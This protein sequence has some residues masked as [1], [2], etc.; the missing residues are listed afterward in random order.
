MEAD[1]AGE[2]GTDRE[3]WMMD[4]TSGKAGGHRWLLGLISCATLLLASTA[5]PTCSTAQQ[6]VITAPVHN[7]H[8]SY[9]ERIGI[10]MDYSWRGPR[11]YMFFNTHGLF[12]APPPFGGWDGND[13][14]FGFGWNRGNA[15]FNFNMAFGQG[16][17]RTH[18]MVA[19]SITVPNGYG[20]SIFSG[21]LRPFVTGIVPV[22]G[23]GWSVQPVIPFRP[24]YDDLR[25][26]LRRINDLER[27]STQTNS[28]T[29]R[30]PQER[31]PDLVLGSSDNPP[32]A[33]RFSSSADRGDESLAAIRRQLENEDRKQLAKA[34]EL[35]IE[36]QQAELSG[37]K[38]VARIFYRQ[39]A[40]RCQG[41]LQKK[42]LLHCE[43]LKQ[44]T[45]EK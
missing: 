9:Y 38:G 13:G 1:V 30:D 27:G 45:S 2:A 25:E 6:V 44:E 40:N 32:A 28:D 17:T 36:G 23:Q 5:Y 33:Q 24:N 10:G 37:K 14:T 41:E 34:Y 39:A 31:E 3:L 15:R 8:D 19:P 18:T 20:G 42:L 29:P 26:K 12:A 4:R 35:I 21:S 7:I 11:G 22:V 43:R 16:N